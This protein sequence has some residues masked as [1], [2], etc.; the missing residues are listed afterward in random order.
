MDKYDPDGDGHVSFEDF[1][2]YVTE[3]EKALR[4][5]FESLD[6]KRDGL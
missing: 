3:H 5:S 1:V 6:H 4:L 2:R